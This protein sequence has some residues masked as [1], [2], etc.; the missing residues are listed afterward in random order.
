MDPSIERLRAP[1][2]TKKVGKI[3][4]NPQPTQPCADDVR[5]P[6]LRRC[7]RKIPKN[8]HESRVWRFEVREF[9]LARERRTPAIYSQSVGELGYRAGA[10]D[11]SRIGTVVHFEPVSSPVLLSLPER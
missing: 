4:Q 6:C 9:G 2:P 8:Y 3:T 10:I 11:S 1:R 7:L 5:A